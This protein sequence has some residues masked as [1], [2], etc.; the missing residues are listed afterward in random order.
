M[1]KQMSNGL[2][3]KQMSNELIDV[4]SKS[5]DRANHYT[6][7]P[8]YVIP[9]FFKLNDEIYIFHADVTENAN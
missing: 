8:Q 3:Q 7:R 2:M 1:Q 4:K 6:C 5:H 9:L